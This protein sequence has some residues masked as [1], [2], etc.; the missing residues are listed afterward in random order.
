M[1]MTSYI[2][3][4]P[5]PPLRPSM[6]ARQFSPHILFSTCTI[7]ADPMRSLS[8]NLFTFFLHSIAFAIFF[9]GVLKNHTPRYPQ[10]GGGS[11]SLFFNITLKRG[12]T[13]SA[14]PPVTPTYSQQLLTPS[15]PGPSGPPPRTSLQSPP[16]SILFISPS[17]RLPLTVSS[18]VS[19]LPIL[20][21]PIAQLFPLVCLRFYEYSCLYFVPS[22]SPISPG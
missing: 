3:R 19:N 14:P 2:F 20:L 21:S 9:F 11:N 7:L 1:P 18:Q 22:T 10:L 17:C 12:D 15:S 8:P 16:W 5:S 13:R 6:K 4:T